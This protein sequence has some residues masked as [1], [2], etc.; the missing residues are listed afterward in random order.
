MKNYTGQKDN[1]AGNIREAKAFCEGIEV[2]YGSAGSVAL[3]PHEIGSE[4]SDAWLRGWNL[5]DGSG[6]TVAHADAPNC[7]IPSGT[8]A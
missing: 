1:N 4:A 5:A 7:A 8:V 2:R 3:N 6:G